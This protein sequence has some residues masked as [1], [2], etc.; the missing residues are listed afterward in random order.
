MGNESFDPDATPVDGTHVARPARMRAVP[1]ARDE[2][3]SGRGT[4]RGRR[5]S[6]S[7]HFAIPQALAFFLGGSLVLLGALLI[8]EISAPSMFSGL[9]NIASAPRAPHHQPVPTRSVHHVPKPSGHGPVL[10]GLSPEIAMPGSTI[11]LSGTGFFSANDEI[12][13]RVA[14]HPAPTRCPTE[15][16]CFVVLP[17]APKGTTESTV[18]VVTES[19]ASN[20]LSIRYG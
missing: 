13:V 5:E 12:V 4:A 16:R 17:A 11:E 15:Q 6:A 3:L 20:S 8:T 2:H 18:Q 14:G 1:T 7:F 10:T 9:R 19:G